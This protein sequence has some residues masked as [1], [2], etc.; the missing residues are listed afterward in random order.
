MAGHGVR[1]LPE[2]SGGGE[3]WQVLL[4]R[5]EQCHLGFQFF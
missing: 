4:I 2:M 3:D 1:W 5:K